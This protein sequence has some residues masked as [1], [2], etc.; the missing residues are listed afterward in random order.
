MEPTKDLTKPRLEKREKLLQMG[1]DPYGGRFEVSESIAVAREDPTADREVR[2]AGR[3]L[4][5]RDMGKSLFADIKDSSSKIQIYVQKQ[6]LSE[7]QFDLFKHFVDLGDIVG[8]AGTLF[9]THAGE[10]TVKVN[11]VTLLSK[12]IQPLPKEWYGI[13]DI[14]TRLRQRY[15]D[16]ILND[17][18]RETFQ[19]RSRIVAEIRSFLEARGFI[20]VETPMMQSMAG[21]AVAK[22][23]K[24]HHEAL[25]VDLFLRVAPE[26]Y[27]KRLL[28]GGFER[29]YEINRNFRNEGVSR[30]HNPEFTM[31]EV[32]QAYGDY[33]TMMD[34]A[35]G[36]IISVAESTTDSLLIKRYDGQEIDLTPPWR[37]VKYRTLV[38]EH[39]GKEWFTLKSED[40][41]ARAITM[42][43][44]IP[45]GTP[46][47]EVTNAIFEKTI[48][49]SL[50]NPTFV[51]HLPAELVVLAKPNKEDPS[52]VDV[53]ELV[54]NGQEIAPAYSE[55]NDPV[56]QRE[57]LLAQAA[58]HAEKLDEDF[59]RALEY[60]MPPA[61][62]MGMGIDRL[63]MMLTGAESI[64][65]VILFPQLRPNS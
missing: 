45:P 8:V 32:Y 10:L 38:E 46:D 22:P 16:L 51:T 54:I 39:L 37:R 11:S 42:G 61:G 9:T 24:T 1:I 47:Y 5:H 55:L 58:G 62:G 6:A 14:E 40:R 19:A 18:V 33:E 3:M 59:L 52:V 17:K 26:L 57:R 64:R 2:L 63:V 34:L 44:E 31:L 43:I 36:L 30:R 50:M 20:E 21:G 15:L 29:V 56:V 48:E 28:V 7:Q 49:P 35:Q 41:K 65:D 60:G 25:D 53:F 4:S 13:R 12:A 23:F 27:L